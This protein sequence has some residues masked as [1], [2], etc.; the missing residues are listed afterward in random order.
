MPY[1]STHTGPEVDASVA[2]HKTNPSDRAVL[3]AL[4][5]GTG[6]VRLHPT[7]FNLQCKV[8]SDWHDL[9]FEDQGDSSISIIVPVAAQE[10]DND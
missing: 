8:G 2:W 10:P 5:A 3:A 6:N 9:N 4:R 7:T 1:N